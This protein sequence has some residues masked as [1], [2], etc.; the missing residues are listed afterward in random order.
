MVVPPG[1]AVETEPPGLA[2]CWAMNNDA[3]KAVKTART[4]RTV[5]RRRPR[6]RLLGRVASAAGVVA[7]IGV[8]WWL[9]AACDGASTRAGGTGGTIGGATTGVPVSDSAPDPD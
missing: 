5:T 1:G 8:L 7:G 4:G 2:S 6:I 9:G 3:A